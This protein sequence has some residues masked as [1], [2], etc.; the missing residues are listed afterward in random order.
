MYTNPN[1]P[2]RFVQSTTTGPGNPR[3]RNPDVGSHSFPNTRRHLQCH[4]LAHCSVTL[5]VFAADAERFP[6]HVIVIGDD[7]AQKDIARTWN[8]RDSLAQ[9]ST[10]AALGDRELEPEGTAFVEHDG[11]EVRVVF[12]VGVRRYPAP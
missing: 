9:H 1:E 8:V 7:A 2:D 3:H 5:D 11:R 10:G 12:S 6:L 4:L